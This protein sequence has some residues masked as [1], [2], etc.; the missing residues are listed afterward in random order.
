MRRRTNILRAISRLAH[1][2]Q[3]ILQQEFLAPVV[4]GR[5]VSV[6]I[7]VRTPDATLVGS[8]KG[9]VN[10]RAHTFTVKLRRSYAKLVVVAS[11]TDGN[12]VT[13]RAVRRIKR[14]KG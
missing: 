11:V 5:K 13:A 8:K 1:V 7:E 3:E 2:E 10:K 9:R 12:G 6:R 4:R 14:P